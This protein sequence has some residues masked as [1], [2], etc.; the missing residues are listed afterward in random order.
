MS[1]NTA[2]TE[3][4]LILSKPNVQ[5][6]LQALLKENN[7]SVAETMKIHRRNLIQD[8]NLSVSQ[9]AVQDVYK[10]AG[11]MNNKQSETTINIALITKE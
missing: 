3:G 5:E 9:T 1:T 7:L 8:D 11:L 2:K 10:I 6:A 4:S